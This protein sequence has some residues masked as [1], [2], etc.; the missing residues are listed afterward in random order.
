MN[1]ARTR[2]LTA[3]S[4]YMVQHYELEDQDVKKLA[5]ILK[6]IGIQE[7]KHAESLAERILFLKGE[8]VTKPDAGAVKGQGIAAMMTTDIGLEDD[9]VKLYNEAA[10][11][12]AAEKD[13]VSKHLFE[14]L[15]E[16]EEGHLNLFQNTLDHIEK[17]GAAYLATLMG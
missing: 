16:D 7:M 14:Q 11:I 15:L 13:E 1:Q 4:Q 5:S 2:E 12:C 8:P 3:I 17:L 9:A 10:A 6:E